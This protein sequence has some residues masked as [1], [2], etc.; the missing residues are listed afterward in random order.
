LAWLR[1][2]EGLLQGG[3]DVAPIGGRR[4][5]GGFSFPRL[6]RGLNDVARCAGS[7]RP[8]A[9]RGSSFD[10]KSV[11]NTPGSKQ[12]C[13][14]LNERVYEN[15]GP[16][17]D[18]SKRSLNVHENKGPCADKFKR[19]WNVIENKGSYAQIACIMIKIKHLFVVCEVI[20][21]PSPSCATI[22]TPQPL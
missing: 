11:Y 2:I 5:H 14:K 20:V 22:A 8:T 10:V 13:K 3:P 17:S 7:I 18:N 15:K 12:D 21:P 1:A 16:C 4:R 6:R 9:L 19:S